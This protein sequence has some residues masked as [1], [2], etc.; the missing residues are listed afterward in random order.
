MVALSPSDEWICFTDDAAAARLDLQAPTVS[1]VRVR[2]RVAPTRA[3]A[4]DGYRKP[5]DMLR[6]TMAVWRNRP[7]VFFSP[8]VYTYFPLPP[9]L[10]AVVA[11]HDAIPERFPRLTLP[12]LRARLFW[13][14][15]TRLA[16]A[17]SKTVLTVSEFSAREIA[18]R[19]GVPRGRIRVVPEAPAAGYRPGGTSEIE[20]VARRYGLDPARPWFIYVGGFNPHKRVDTI[21]RAHAEITKDA[22]GQG[23]QL[24]LVGTTDADVFHGNVQ[25]IRDLARACGTEDRVIWTG[26][27]PDA[28][29]R[30]LYSGATALVI[31]SEAE[32]FG[33]PAVEA[34]ACG[35]PVIATTESPLPGILAG[36]GFFVNPGDVAAI[37]TAMG[38]L[39]RDSRLRQAMGAQAQARAMV[40]SWAEAAKLTLDA[41]RQAGRGESVA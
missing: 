23:A 5:L 12:G 35:A 29:L 7:D 8:S 15:K 16:I 19:L 4:A 18:G 10:P 24:A 13:K 39:L 2:Q 21:V 22:A 40:L 3:A 11:I 31:V 32:G 30:H 37:G 27:V 9:G 17:Q 26:F 38:N 20:A 34:A 14:W 41:L 36:G 28:D 6:F 33:L 25:E 1:V